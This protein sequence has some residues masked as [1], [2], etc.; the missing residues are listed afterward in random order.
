MLG[1]FVVPAARLVE[2]GRGGGR[3]PARAGRGR[4]LATERA[5]SAPTPHGDAARVD[6]VQR[7]ARRA[8]GR[9]R[10]R[11]EGGEPGAGRRGAGGAPARPHGLR[12]GPARREPRAACSQRSGAA[13]RA[14]RSAPAASCPRRSRTPA[15]VA[16]FIAACAAAG[17]AW[18]ATAGLHHPVRAEQALTYEPASPRAVMHGFLNVFAAA[19]FARAGATLAELEAVLREHAATALPLRRRRASRWRQRRATTDAARGR[20]ARLRGAPSAPAR[21]PSRWPTCTRSEC[22][23]DPE[24]G[25]H[26]R[27]GAASF[28]ESAN[29]PAGDFPVQNLPLGVFRRG[30]DGRAR[31]GCA[32]G[33]RVLDLRACGERGLL[34]GL[35]SDVEAACAGESLNALMALDPRVRGTLRH[36]LSHLLRA[37]GGFVTARNDAAEVLLPPRGRRDAAAR[38]RSATTPTSTPRSSTPRTSA[39]CCAPTTRCCPTTSGCRSATTAAPRRSS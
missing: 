20:A 37:E 26:A 14:R 8:G 18:K 33:D 11:A 34:R 19:A 1:R 15:D 31:V 9:G 16:R 21:S 27:R 35:P 5:R 3:A 29:D 28:V 17:V 32:I 7:R 2:L 36:R 6:V 39:R 10:G 24:D 23:G 12:R 4:A 13:G 38:G 25:R 30:G 22:S